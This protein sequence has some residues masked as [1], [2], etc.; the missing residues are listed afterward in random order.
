MNYRHV[1]HA[2]NFA[3]VLKH[4][5]L[6]LCLDYLL[7]KDGPLCIIDA[8]AGAGLYDLNSEEA[9][10]TG[11]W[12]KGIGLLLEAAAPPPDLEPYL[13]LVADDM[14]LGQYPGSPLLIS[15]MKRTK[16]RLI[17]CELHEPTFK[18]LRTVLEP[19][20]N[21]LVLWGNAY[22]CIRANLPPAERR[23][24]VLI[25]PPFE[26]KDEFD[27]LIRQMTQWKRRWA[28]GVFLL[29][30]PIKA[31]LQ[32]DE[33]KAAARALGMPRTWFSEILVSPREQPN[34]MNGCGIIVFNAPYMAPERM[35]QSLA[36]MKASMSLHDI[37][38]GWLI[39]DRIIF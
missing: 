34:T 5:A 7:K 25:D 31:H 29:W 20:E 37:S 6:T 28:T 1:Y 13:G 24:L 15:R 17:A 4:V 8:H 22:G 3:D 2:G 30:Y 33:L 10:R 21:K 32:V 23:G 39:E 38:A 18:T 26:K 14:R 19:T 12:R 16:D 11:E 35:E 9:A 27:T 36:F